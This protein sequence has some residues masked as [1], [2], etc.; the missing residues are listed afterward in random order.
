MR[1]L[2]YFLAAILISACVHFAF[3]GLFFI[4]ETK[5]GSKK[6]TVSIALGGN[7]E[8]LVEGPPL[9]VSKSDFQKPKKSNS[10]LK[11]T[12]GAVIKKKVITGNGNSTPIRTLTVKMAPA[13]T[14]LKTFDEQNNLSEQNRPLVVIKTSRPITGSSISSGWR[15]EGKIGEKL[16]PT[17]TQDLLAFRAPS[18]VVQPKKID[19]TLVHANIQNGSRTGIQKSF[20]GTAKSNRKAKQEPNL[21]ILPAE[22]E[23]SFRTVNPQRLEKSLQAMSKAKT[24]LARTPSTQLVKRKK[25]LEQVPSIQVLSPLAPKILAQAPVKRESTREENE[26]VPKLFV[27][28]RPRARPDPDETKKVSDT[29]IENS[30]KK[31]NSFKTA[32]LGSAAGQQ[33]ETFTE[34]IVPTNANNRS[35]SRNLRENDYWEKVLR[36]IDR[37]KGGSAGRSGT[38]L[39]DLKIGSDGRILSVSVKK[40]SGISRVDNVAVRKVKRARF[41]APTLSGKKESATLRVIVKG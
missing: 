8:N 1:S 2:A 6:N 34:E 5:P 13:T 15:A 18:T 37:T 28:L 9:T 21:H 38:V 25:D 22:V 19:Q 39:I 24:I 17:V 7:F 32:R 11:P 35:S 31:S 10:T 40:S 14:N 36:K 29:D 33:T 20:V 4:S 30:S 23:Q 12:S 26:E 16:L 3:A 27:S 41:F